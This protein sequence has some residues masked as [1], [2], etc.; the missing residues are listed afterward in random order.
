MLRLIAILFHLCSGLTRS[1]PG[2]PDKVAKSGIAVGH[3]WLIQDLRASTVL[4][5]MLT[6]GFT[7]LL[8][9]LRLAR[10]ERSAVD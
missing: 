1:R 8:S 10:D 3:V 4:V 5:M 6:M 9:G 7:A 2:S